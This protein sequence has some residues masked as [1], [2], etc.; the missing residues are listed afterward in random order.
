MQYANCPARE[1]RAIT[2]PR[3]SADSP[4]ARNDPVNTAPKTRARYRYQDEC[5]AL[6]ILQ[7]LAAED[8]QE[9]YVEHPTDFVLI[10]F[11]EKP[12]LVSIKHRESTH[13]ESPSWRLSDLKKENVLKDLYLAWER[14]DRQCTVAFLS[15]AGLSG[16]ASDL[17]TWRYGDRERKLRIAM[18]AVAA[19]AD[20]SIN[21]A[22]QFLEALSIPENPLPRRN[23]ISDVGVQATARL[24][25]S[26]GRTEPKFAE[27]CYLA[28]VN[29]LT[30][31]AMD[32]PPHERRNQLSA[33]ATNALAG[34][35]LEHDDASHRNY[36][37]A[38]LRALLLT[39]YDNAAASR[40]PHSGREAIYS[41]PLFTGRATELAVL[42]KLLFNERGD[43]GA[44]VV[45]FGASGCGKSALATEFAALHRGKC[46][47]YLLDGSTRAALLADVA[48]LTGEDTSQAEPVR[49]LLPDVRRALFI[50]DGVPH[51]E[52]ISGVVRRNSLSRVI[53]TSTAR[54]LDHGF[55]YL[56]LQSWCPEESVEY[57]HRTLPGREDADLLKLANTLYNTPLAVA[58][59]AKYC[60]DINLA[61][62]Q[63]LL[64]LAERP[65]RILARGRAD[66]Y[67]RSVVAAIELNISAVHGRNR[68]AADML[69]L[70]SFLG[71]SPVPEE[72][73]Q[74]RAPLAWIAY[75]PPPDRRLL[76]LQ[77]AVERLWRRW[78]FAGITRQALRFR[79]ALEME[80]N[81]DAAID[82]LVHSLLVKRTDEGLL[83]HPLVRLIVRDQQTNI[84]PWLEVGLG[85]L[86]EYFDRDVLEKLDPVLPHAEL[87]T[88]VA[89]EEGYV[90]VALLTSCGVLCDRLTDLGDP[91]E[92]SRFGSYAVSAIEELWI[93]NRTTPNIV[94]SLR[95]SL[96]RALY[97]RGDREAAIPLL[98]SNMAL[99]SGLGSQ[100]YLLNL[101]FLAT[102]A[103]LVEDRELNERILEH[104]PQLD[105]A[106]PLDLPARIA[107]AHGRF[108]ILRRLNRLDEAADA[109]AWC[110]QKIAEAPELTR[111]VKI[112]VHEDAA[113]LA[114]DQG[115]GLAAYRNGLAALE[116][117]RQSH[118]S[119]QRIVDRVF[120]SAIHG[121]AD[122]AIEAG[123]IGKAEA[124]L[125]EGLEAAESQYGK[126]HEIYAGVQAILGRLRFVQG[127]LRVALVELEKSSSIL[128]THGPF[129]PSA[130]AFGPHPPRTSLRQAWSF[131]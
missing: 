43:E 1:A 82:D 103:P 116:A 13:S 53:I 105:E 55:H 129:V 111:E 69:V 127:N 52:V 102:S 42:K 81:A 104:I 87:L 110:L 66:R 126:S 2:S 76:R 68:L 83:L 51:Q 23:E 92:G 56:E 89:M 74:R 15:N 41:D 14:A 22:R 35:R 32:V 109:V 98:M 123:E 96:A 59:A 95:L 90:G 33:A 50:I 73:L 29:D 8:L 119:G 77:R 48:K 101:R 117:V 20:C 70:L 128:E 131:C 39:T 115:D 40:L 94:L 113:R 71:Q 125:R 16:E 80:D 36:S 65:A 72:L 3:H 31:G 75:N 67:P 114:R 49:L 5:V 79:R 26:L 37:A 6:A 88:E 25:A 57:L 107:L 9:I 106:V 34:A 45:I 64:R 108:L 62:E 60:D 112:L 63:Y 4:A 100:D 28:L 12:E 124:L 18:T 30:R 84:R 44:P 19:Q 46:R 10:P 38:Y 130:T 17:K 58:Q 7:R 121:A 21:D 91:A 97:L 122:G 86:V 54:R 24:L 11:N 78:K 85:L 27:Q 93:N 61:V 120:M 99:T 118:A 47:A